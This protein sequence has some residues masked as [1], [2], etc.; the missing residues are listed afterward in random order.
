MYHITPENKI[1]SIDFGIVIDE[2]FSL[3]P[4]SWYYTEIC[5]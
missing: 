2:T 1:S 4:F 5:L 3:D